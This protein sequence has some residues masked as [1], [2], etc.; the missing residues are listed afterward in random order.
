[1]ISDPVSVPLFVQGIGANWQLLTEI[2]EMKEVAHFG[3][4]SAKGE[5]PTKSLGISVRYERMKNIGVHPWKS[6]GDS[7]EPVWVPKEP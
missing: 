3:F 5:F 6:L 1:M 4:V 2:S 7:T